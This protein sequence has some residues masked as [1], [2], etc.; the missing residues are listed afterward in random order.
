MGICY[1]R[2]AE[3][4]NRTATAGWYNTAEFHKAAK[5]R[6]LYARSLNGDAFSDDIKRQAA[7]IIK[8]DLG[9]VDLVVHSL[10]SLRRT[11]PQ[12][13]EVF[14]T[15]LKPIKG[16]YTNKSF[17]FD[18]NEVINVTLEPAT[19]DE[20]RQTVG[21]M[22]GE[23]W[24]MWIDLLR[25][26]NL[27]APGC[28]TLAYSYIGPEVTQ[29]IYRQGTIGNAKAHLE[30]TARKLD[31]QLAQINGRA[32]VSV[33]KAMVTQASSVIPFVSLYIVLLME[34]MREKRIHEGCIEQIT[35]LF[36]ERLYGR[37]RNAI[38]VDAE[39]RARMDDLEMRP[40][41]QK[42]VGKKWVAVT[43]ANIN[44]FKG[45]DNYY[46]DFLRLFGFG[47]EGVDYNVDVDV[48]VQIEGLLNYIN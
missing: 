9:Q 30:A 5:D 24:G 12:T 29:P 45:V 6:G 41:V 2:P 21:V 1:E 38:P 28:L 36:H 34:T 22:G 14:R 37:S 40:D 7:D 44:R 25:S 16:S 31:K 43:T 10:A 11:H 47:F 23:D 13:G 3:H 46:K 48:N 19:D 32:L 33:N 27:L 8:R 26:E 15:C 4:G 39:G 35:R 17:D 42:E 18:K 20:V